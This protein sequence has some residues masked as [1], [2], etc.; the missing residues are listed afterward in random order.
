MDRTEL[1]AGIAREIISPPQGIYLIGYGDRTKGNTGIHDDLTATALVLD[2]GRTRL[3]LVAC[4]NDVD[5]TGPEPPEFEAVWV[6]A[7]LSAWRGGSTEARLLYDGKHIGFNH[8]VCDPE[9][10]SC[11]ELKVTGYTE[12]SSG[13]HTIEVQVMDQPSTEV[14]WQVAAEVRYQSGGQAEIRLGPVSRTLR[15]GDSVTFEI[16][17]P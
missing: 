4:D 15:E 6:T 3:A 12:K 10:R 1:R 17:I 14:T 5:I 8:D 13:R 16:E 9:G 11:G 7:T 2:D